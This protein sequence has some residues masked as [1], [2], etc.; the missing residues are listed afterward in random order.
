MKNI[1]FVLLVLFLCCSMSLAQG[2]ENLAGN[3]YVQI[4]TAVAYQ[5]PI[6][7]GNVGMICQM[8]GAGKGFIDIKSGTDPKLVRCLYPWKTMPSKNRILL[9][10]GSITK[11]G[12]LKVEDITIYTKDILGAH[13]YAPGDM[14]ELDSNRDVGRNVAISG[15]V[16]GAGHND[17]GPYFD[18]LGTKMWLPERVT[19]R[20]YC[21]K[22]FVSVAKDEYITAFG[23]VE[24][25]RQLRVVAINTNNLQ[26]HPPVP[27]PDDIRRDP[28]ERQPAQ[29]NL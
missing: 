9:I 27:A 16:M 12:Q 15:W 23:S 28:N 20:C 5:N 7:E 8:V 1:V 21:P 6:V 25:Q 4:D 19:T 10:I 29:K 11:P 22:D 13:I 2:N 26:R 17:Y 18:L 3:D 14:V 24:S